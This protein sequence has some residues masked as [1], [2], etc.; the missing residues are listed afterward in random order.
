MGKV[1]FGGFIVQIKQMFSS[2]FSSLGG[3]VVFYCTLAANGLLS[4][5]YQKLT[6]D[7]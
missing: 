5:L 2:P 3:H 4:F 7:C 6:S 1:C